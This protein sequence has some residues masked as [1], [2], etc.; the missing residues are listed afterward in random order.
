ME[1]RNLFHAQFQT[2]EELSS[3]F[4]AREALLESLARSLETPPKKHRL[5]LAPWGGGK[6]HLLSLLFHQVREQKKLFPQWVPVFVVGRD[7]HFSTLG[8]LLDGFFF[9]IRHQPDLAEYQEAYR[10]VRKGGA[11][12][13]EQWEKISAILSAMARDKNKR[14][15]LC[16]D[17][18]DV[19]HDFLLH[20]PS[21]QL[22]SSFLAFRE[23]VSIVGTA[24]ADPMEDKS[25]FSLAGSFDLLPLLPLDEKQTLA[26]LEKTSM[27]GGNDGVSSAIRR[28]LSSVRALF[29][30]TR[31]NPRLICILRHVLQGR[32]DFSPLAALRE[33]LDLLSPHY[34]F[35]IQNTPAKERKLLDCLLRRYEWVSPSELARQLG[36][37][38]KEV[39]V[40]LRRLINR[41]LVEKV[42]PGP[43]KSFYGAADPLF[44]AYY[45][46][47]FV[48]ELKN[49]PGE[50]LHFFQ[51][52]HD[53]RHWSGNEKPLASK[54]GKSVR[55][56]HYLEPPTDRPTSPE[57]RGIYALFAERNGGRVI[58]EIQKV[59]ETSPPDPEAR[60]PLLFV[61]GFIYSM[62]GDHQQAI[63]CYEKCS[64]KAEDS[65]WFLNNMGCDYRFLGFREKA[66]DCYERALERQKDFS[67]V[68]A[69]LGEARRQLGQIDKAVECFL[70]FEKTVAGSPLSG[71]FPPPLAQLIFET[72]ALALEGMWLKGKEEACVHFL[73]ER[74]TFILS[75]PQESAALAL[76]GLLWPLVKTESAALAER[77]L[78]ILEESLPSETTSRLHPL[79]VAVRYLESGREEILLAQ[80][81][82]VR[83]AVQ[84]ALRTQM[85]ITHGL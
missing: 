72:Y 10:S 7:S 3:G 51:G 26:L 61:L 65:S 48:D 20:D 28:N 31:G 50:L 6:T 25:S 5:I 52:L 59:L 42:R 1:N 70:R 43:K 47:Q 63:D 37:E 76:T 56:I 30:F 49:R 82:E 19:L 2:A 69:N 75:L 74:L 11:D 46:I 67:P 17:D 73:N 24:T 40:L 35:L 21:S 34:R 15:L 4:A 8:D 41:G 62:E 44:C 66:V 14:F 39:S 23:F 64:V 58:E 71:E 80:N 29:H 13:R 33:M 27:N 78:R 84:L 38:G 85:D 12:I 53:C 81:K 32:K 22:L 9:Q 60:T 45:H 77:V 55:A 83:D 68:L 57:L 36:W 79:A 16:V 54:T 18:F